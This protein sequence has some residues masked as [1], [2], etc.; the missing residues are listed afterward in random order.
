MKGKTWTTEELQK[1]FE[2]I[3][4]SMG[5]VVVKRLSDGQLGSM[6]FDHSPRIYYSFKE[7]KKEKK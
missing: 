4:F 2:V 1:E 7:D 6:D 3:G 5:Y